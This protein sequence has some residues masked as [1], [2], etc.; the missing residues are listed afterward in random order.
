MWRETKDG[1]GAR[2]DDEN[3][4]DHSGRIAEAA[5]LNA[6]ADKFFAATKGFDA[7]LCSDDKPDVNAGG[8]AAGAG[9]SSAAAGAGSAAAAARSV[10]RARASSILSM[11]FDSDDDETS[12]R[13]QPSGGSAPRA[14]LGKK[15][16]KRLSATDLIAGALEM[17]E[18]RYAAD[19]AER[20]EE[21]QIREKHFSQLMA[22]LLPPPSIPPAPVD[23]GDAPMC[24]E[25][26]IEPVH[27]NNPKNKWFNLCPTCQ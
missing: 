14:K 5:E 22:A 11:I 12:A 23:H 1:K 19:V 20:K 25:C 6:L 8:A 21:K 27:W 2:V 13:A 7:D 24:R 26:G 3:V 9:A 10:P 16:V 4:L 15:P 17:N 18:K